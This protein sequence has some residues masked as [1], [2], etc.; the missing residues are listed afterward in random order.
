MTIIPSVC[1]DMVN[2]I[3]SCMAIKVLTAMPNKA[4]DICHLAKLKTS[5][6]S[7]GFN[8]IFLNHARQHAFNQVSAPHR[9]CC[10]YTHISNISDDG[11]V[12]R[13]VYG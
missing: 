11:G 8:Y 3:R 2:Y 13:V 9:Q 4:S 5:S 6:A 7:F 10:I 12:A 1:E